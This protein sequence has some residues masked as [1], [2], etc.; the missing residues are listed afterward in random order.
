MK[1]SRNSAST[2][3][4]S[5]TT[6]SPSRPAAIH[7]KTSINRL[8]D[9][10]HYLNTTGDKAHETTR[11]WFD[12]RANLRREME[13]RKRRFNDAQDVRP[14]LAE[15]LRKLTA[16]ATFFEDVHI[17]TPHGDVPDDAGLRLVCLP[18]EAF[19]SRSETRLAF[20]EV[21]PKAARECYR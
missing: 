17:F 19:F 20:D 5:P 12:T 8:A 21:L 16:G 18:P 13:D 10:L 15:A 7:S 6:W 1:C 9:R 14:K 11:F 2:S 4:S 3:A